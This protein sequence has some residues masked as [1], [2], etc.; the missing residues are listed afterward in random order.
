MDG[1]DEVRHHR[2]MFAT[3][4]EL[5]LLE[6]VRMRS[7]SPELTNNLLDVFSEEEDRYAPPEQLRNL[8]EMDALFALCNEVELENAASPLPDLPTTKKQA[9]SLAAV[10]PINRTSPRRTNREGAGR[11]KVRFYESDNSRWERL[12]PHAATRKGPAVSQAQQGGPSA[13][14]VRKLMVKS[15]I[16]KKRTP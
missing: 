10:Q 9:M 5:G 1:T 16:R 8:E 7:E 4:A 2:Y 6:D 12:P 15:T 14:P 3:R 11:R 13:A